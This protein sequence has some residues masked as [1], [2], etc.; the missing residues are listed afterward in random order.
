MFYKYRILQKNKWT[1]RN[2]CLRSYIKTNETP[3][4]RFVSFA[5]KPSL[6]LLVVLND[7][8]YS[9][10]NVTFMQML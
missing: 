6:K 3:K 7:L 10:I 2:G 4:R 1:K 9:L 8:I 5:F